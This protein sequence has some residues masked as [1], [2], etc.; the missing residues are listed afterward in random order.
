MKRKPHYNVAIA[1]AT[2]A[3]GQEFLTVLNR[4]D[5]PIA[6]LRL[7]ASERSVGRSIEYRGKKYPV[8][9]LCYDSFAGIDIALFSAGGDRSLEFAP[10]AV[11]AGAVVVDNSSAY[12][13]DP[14]VP[15]VVPEINPEDVKKHKG[16]I[17]NPNC[18]TI[19]ACMA[20]WP[21]HRINP[22]KRMVLV[23]YQAVSGAGAKAIDE[24]EQQTREIL[25]GKSPKPKIFR[26]P[27]AF[28]LFSHDSKIGEEGYTQEEMK[29]VQETRKIFHDDSIRISPT[30]VRVPIFRAHAEAI[31]LELSK[32]V[33]LATLQKALS[34]MPGVKIV[35][36][37]EKNYFPMPRE[38]SGKD[39]VFI[40]RIRRDL[41]LENGLNLF[42]CG[43]QLLKGA[44]LNAVQ[45]AELL[46]TK[47]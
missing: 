5:F 39:E 24:L 27:I 28:N 35:D 16:I 42:V 12:R 3:V 45:I 21:I 9:E 6:E 30:T 32:R 18:T 26:H 44:A 2:G 17:A 1:G 34:A 22:V 46:V 40:G 43:D 7:L 14:S 29:V 10:S 47:C 38:V 31:H 25:E 19:I 37:R 13:M 15:L 20:V 41:D 4:R 36:D 8:S 11:K 23:T 33:D